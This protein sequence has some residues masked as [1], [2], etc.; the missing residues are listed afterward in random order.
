M[1]ERIIDN[2]ILRCKSER[3]ASDKRRSEA[4]KRT[5]RRQYNDMGPMRYCMT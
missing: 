1:H 5:L 4:I 2:I 3:K